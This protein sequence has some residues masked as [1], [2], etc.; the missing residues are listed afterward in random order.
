MSIDLSKMPKLGF[1]LMRLPEVNGVIDMDHVCKMVDAY[2]KMGKCYFDTAYVYHGGN[3]ET[4]AREAL[5]KR[6]PRDSF[7]IATKLPAWEIKKE[8]DIERIFN[9]QLERAGVDFFDLYLLHSVEDG[10]NYDT[11]VKYDCF[12]WGLKK[13]EEGQIKHLGFSYHGSPELLVKILDEHPEMEFVQI[14]L[15]YLDRTNPVVRSEELYNILRDRNIPII[16]MEPVRGGMLADMAPEIEAK[17]KAVHPDRSIASWALRYTASLPGVMTVLSGMSNIDQV[18]D[19]I[20]TFTDL[21]P[22]T[23][24]EMNVIDKVTEEIL[25]IP[26][27]GCTACKYCTP[28]CPMKISIPDVFRTI[29]TLRRY[30]DD[31]RSKNFYSG[32]VT[33]SGKASACIACGQCEKVCPQH[34]P[35]IEL[36]QEAAGI[37]DQ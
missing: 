14:Q 10:S 37:L 2:M 36:L 8:S 22:I 34:L 27:I 7:M 15:N 4:A 19:N 31:W 20:D 16:I 24:A 29:N 32:L 5:V 26:Q 23:D 30:P 35:I 17:F 12:S 21:E 6:Y 18:N 1:G 11:Y 25:S 9:E 3:S 28:G 33:R 13:K